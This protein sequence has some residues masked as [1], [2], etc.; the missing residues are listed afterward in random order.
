MDHEIK[1]PE[2]LAPAG[3]ME[4]FRAAIDYG[5]DAVYIGGQRFGMRAAPKNFDFEQMEEATSYAHKNGAKVYMTCNT[6]PRNDELDALPDFL[7]SAQEAGID[8]FI[9]TDIGVMKM[10]Q[11]YAPKCEV[12]ISTQA[13][14]TNYAAANAFYAL[15]AKRIVTARE[16]SL[17][18]IAE[19]RR[20]IP[21]DL[22]IESFVH[23]AMC[24]SFS[25]RCMLSNYLTGRDANRGDCA[26]PCRWQ[27]HIVE[28]TRPNEPMPIMEDGTGTYIFNSKDMC[29]IEH[30]PEVISAGISSLKIEGRAKSAYYVAVVVNAYRAALDGYKQNP[31]PD[32][33]PPQW[34][35]D[36]M[37]KVSYREYCT[38]FYFDK[39]IENAQIFE[40][41][42]YRRSWDVMGIVER[43]EDGRAYAVQ[44]NRFFEGDIIEVMRR[45]VPPFTI[46]VEDLRD[47][48]GNKIENVPHP[49]M[50]FSFL[51]DK[52]QPG[53][54]LRK[55]KTE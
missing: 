52:L 7:H 41:G 12:H 17:A 45:G 24:M 30:I 31:S 50:N 9:L 32:Y 46:V 23:G 28:H 29:M 38:G 37:T 34:V 26:Q 6:V 5:A 11:Q 16:L 8:G 53:D 43:C 33:K 15:G 47:K 21:A 2:L 44:R 51:C 13:G 48:E 14:I 36:E 25:G 54:I 4:C 55:A 49:K 22:E 40:E 19:I 18:E 27:Y 3:D 1:L 20:N 35:L 42:G 39:P 10:A